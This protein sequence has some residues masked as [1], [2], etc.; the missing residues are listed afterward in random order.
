MAKKNAN[1]AKKKGFHGPPPVVT[2]TLRAVKPPNSIPENYRHQQAGDW[3]LLKNGVPILL[4]NSGITVRMIPV[5]YS[6][7]LAHGN[8]L[9]D[10]LAPFTDRMIQ[11]HNP[12]TDFT[13]RIQIQQVLT[14]INQAEELD[15]DYSKIH[16]TLITIEDG[17]IKAGMENPSSSQ[18]TLF[19]QSL[20]TELQA[21]TVQGESYDEL[22]E[23]FNDRMAELP[24][25][26]KD[27]TLADLMVASRKF[28]EAYCLSAVI[29]PRLKL[30]WEEA[31]LD[32]NSM[33]VGMLPQEDIQFIHGF[34]NAPLYELVRFSNEQNELLEPLPEG[35]TDED[36]SS[37]SDGSE[38]EDPEIDRTKGN[39]AH[40]IHGE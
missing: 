34:C 25:T 24:E 21:A 19:V 10:Y 23:F 6:I 3:Q 26:S 14:F 4:P 27:I 28:Y 29:E 39:V 1:K 15:P 37:D 22:R 20:M 7:M 16:E 5:D 2:P 30:T 18:T 36:E 17:F 12:L 32:E 33:W 35:S 38:P 13:N 40:P 9:P 31:K 11:G 8:K